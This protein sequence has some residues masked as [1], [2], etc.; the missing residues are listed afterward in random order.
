MELELLDQGEQTKLARVLE[1]FGPLNFRLEDKRA[2]QGDESVMKVRDGGGVPGVAGQGACA[3]VACVVDE[4]GYDYFNNFLGK[5]GGRRRRC[6]RRV[7]RS[8]GRAYPSDSGQT[9]KPNSLGEQLDRYS[10]GQQDAIIKNS[11]W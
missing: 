1:R 4:M 2:G 8:T 10:D 9:S 5:P 3:E 11:R 6:H 7:R